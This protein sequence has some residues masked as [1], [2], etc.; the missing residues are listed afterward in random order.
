MA[1]FAFVESGSIPVYIN[2][3]YVIKIELGLDPR[4][5]TTVKFRDGRTMSLARSEGERLVQQLNLCCI[6]RKKEMQPRKSA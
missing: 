3:D 6:P 1:D 4:E 2:L 5:S